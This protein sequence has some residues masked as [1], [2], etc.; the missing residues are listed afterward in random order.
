MEIAVKFNRCALAALGVVLVFFGALQ[1]AG[2]EQVV[3]IRGKHLAAQEV[4]HQV[5]VQTGMVFRFPFDDKFDHHGDY[6]NEVKVSEVVAAFMDYHRE[7][8]HLDLE[9]VERGRG[10]YLFKTKGEGEKQPASPGL[11]DIAAPAGEALPAPVTKPGTRGL[12]VQIVE[13]GNRESQPFTSHFGTRDAQKPASA[14]MAA[15]AEK[16]GKAAPTPKTSFKERVKSRWGFFT[17][18][19]P[20]AGPDQ[21]HFVSFANSGLLAGFLAPRVLPSRVLAE[22]EQEAQG[23]V[24]VHR[25][26]ENGKAKRFF[27]SYDSDFYRVALAGRIGLAPGL[28][29]SLEIAGLSH[30]GD[31]RIAGIR[32][33]GLDVAFSDAV[34][35]V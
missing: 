7:Y 8:N 14:P 4:L 5:E 34:L 19:K 22:G 1:A 12:D 21:S 18:G 6:D 2:M 25:D 32:S 28:E 3:Q 29:G 15:P 17:Q 23:D 20:G 35:T 24:Q 10:R 16:P 33:G 31:Y 13:R 26:D 27:G 30:S 9:L 11:S